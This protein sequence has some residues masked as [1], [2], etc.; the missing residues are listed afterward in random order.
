VDNEPATAFSKSKEHVFARTPGL[1]KKSFGRTLTSYQAYA[2]DECD[3]LIMFDGGHSHASDY[4][5]RE[6]TKAYPKCVTGCIDLIPR[7]ADQETRFVYAR[8][9]GG[10]KRQK[11]IC[12][13]CL[14]HTTGRERFSAFTNDLELQARPHKH[15]TFPGLESS[16][17]PVLLIPLVDPANLQPRV[18]QQQKKTIVDA[19]G[20]CSRDMVFDTPPQ[21]ALDDAPPHSKTWLFTFDR[22]TLTYQEILWMLWGGAVIDWTPGNGSL[23]YVCILEKVPSTVIVKNVAHREVIQGRLLK[24]IMDDMNDSNNHLFYLSDEQLGLSQE[25]NKEEEGDP[26]P[27]PPTP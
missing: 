11:A 13:G 4:A 16:V 10:A 14:N 8:N 3:V 23:A 22:H 7:E 25:K 5:K 20:D 12:F 15:L 27:P 2:K 17:A 18:T 21:G 24:Q 19:G 26:P 9:S 1:N 6:F